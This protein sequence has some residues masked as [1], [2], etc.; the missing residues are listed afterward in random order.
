[1][2][3]IP[4]DLE[5]AILACLAKDPSDRPATALEL[6]EMLGNCSDAMQWTAERA[7]AW[8]S[9]H[10]E[11]PSSVPSTIDGSRSPDAVLTIDLAART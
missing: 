1:M 5:S 2:P 4:S 8:W 7:R 9:E 3:G 11:L 10:G 6:R